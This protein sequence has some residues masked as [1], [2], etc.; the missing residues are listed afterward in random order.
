MLI[1]LGEEFGIIIILVQLR[2]DSARPNLYHRTI[3]EQ[4][5]HSYSRY[6]QDS[7]NDLAMGRSSVSASAL[8]R[9]LPFTLLSPRLTRNR[10]TGSHYSS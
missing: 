9:R 8:T 7:D 3:T 5:G 10:E 4:R 2:M 1:G 6:R